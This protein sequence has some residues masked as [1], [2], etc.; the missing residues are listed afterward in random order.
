M[1]TQSNEGLDAQDESQPPSL[2]RKLQEE[3][4]PQLLNILQPFSTKWFSIGIQ[5][6]IP[7]H[8]LCQ[9]EADYR[10]DTQRQLIEM[11]DTWIK[12]GRNC[13]RGALI[14]ALDSLGYCE[15]PLQNA[16]QQMELV[17]T[18]KL[19][20][21][22]QKLQLV[23]DLSGCRRVNNNL[24][25][26]T[27]CVLRARP[28][29]RPSERQLNDTVKKLED[30]LQKYDAYFQDIKRWKEQTKE[31]EGIV[32]GLKKLMEWHLDSLEADQRQFADNG[33]EN[34]MTTIIKDVKSN[35]ER[36]TNTLQ[37]ISGHC[38]PSSYDHCYTGSHNGL[39]KS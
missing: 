39:G 27:G 36:C 22:E 1:A 26:L 20:V 13:Y 9:I 35:I 24:D 31:V 19:Q 33:E 15:D 37:V 29:E 32:R 18:E 5:L 14:K 25:D 34:K 28:S 38:G 4:I 30:L 23:E 2:E 11:I 6:Q 7:K 21:N 17:K 12:R 8:I 10:G 16:R 3:D